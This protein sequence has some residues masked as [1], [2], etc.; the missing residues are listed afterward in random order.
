MN[1][2]C[3]LCGH[4][5]IKKLRNQH[6]LA[7]QFKLPDI[8][9][10]SLIRSCSSNPQTPATK[11]TNDSLP[12]DPKSSSAAAGGVDTYWNFPLTN[13]QRMLLVKSGMYPNYQS[14]PERVP[15]KKVHTAQDRMRTR[16][17]MVLTALTLIIALAFCSI[18]SKQRRARIAERDHY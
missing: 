7:Q 11:P 15:A 14:I 16:A 8:Q 2:A 1:S 17:A 12:T 4:H 6:T 3:R 13:F 9:K 5:L 18:W 10:V